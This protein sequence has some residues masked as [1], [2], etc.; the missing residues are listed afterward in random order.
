[1]KS[2]VMLHHYYRSPLTVRSE[3]SVSSQQPSLGEADR[4]GESVKAGYWVLVLK[5]TI[6]QSCLYHQ[7]L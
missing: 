7:F 3:P 4:T 2:E 1:M 5:Y 6:S